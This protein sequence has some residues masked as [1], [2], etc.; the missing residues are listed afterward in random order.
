[1]QSDGNFQK[2]IITDNEEN[3]V[4]MVGVTIA[5]LKDNTIESNGD[6]GISLEF[7][8]RPHMLNNWVSK[9]TFQLRMDKESLEQLENIKFMNPRI[10]GENDLPLN[11]CSIF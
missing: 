1:M 5:N 11:K 4:K 7:P 3:G 2:N 8:A 6:C 10:S 9:N